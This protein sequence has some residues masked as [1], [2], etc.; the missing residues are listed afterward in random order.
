MEKE[1]ENTKEEVLETDDV[2]NINEKI[3]EINEENH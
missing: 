1:K 2:E 3:E